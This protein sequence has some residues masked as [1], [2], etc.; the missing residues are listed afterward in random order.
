MQTSQQIQQMVDKARID[1]SWRIDLKNEQTDRLS[2][3]Y[4]SHAGDFIITP[5]NFQ[6]LR[7]TLEESIKREQ[8]LRES[9]K[10]YKDLLI[11][12][13][14]EFDPAWVSSTIEQIDHGIQISL[15]DQKGEIE[16]YQTVEKAYLLQSQVATGSGITIFL[17]IPF[18]Y[19]VAYK[20]R[21]YK[22]VKIE[23]Q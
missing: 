21:Q 3:W 23:S 4:E 16:N 10:V 2:M 11:K 6:M 7:S 17:V 19:Y 15:N 5:G 14:S 1:Y 9:G 22:I 13:S 12:Y 18:L 20:L 8:A